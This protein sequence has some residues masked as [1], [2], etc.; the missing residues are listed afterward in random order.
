MKLYT[1]RCYGWV[2]GVFSVLLVF[3]ISS[4]GFG[5][6]GVKLSFCNE[7]EQKIFL[8]VAYEP[9]SGQPMLARGWW[10]IDAKK[11]SE[12]E[13]PLIGDK[14]MVYANSENQVTEWRGGRQ[15]CVDTTNKFDFNNAGEMSCQ[16]GT[17]ERRSFR[18]L[19]LREL[20]NSASDGMPRY[21]FTANSSTRIAD[22][23]RL[24]NDTSDTLYLSFSQKSSQDTLLAVAGW[25]KVLSGKCHETVKFS[26]SDE[27]YVF[28]NNERGDKLWKGDVPL[29]TNS[30]DGYLFTEA[31]SM[32]C[33]GNNER[34]QFFK[35]ISM[36]LTGDFEYRLKLIGSESVR[37]MVELCNTAATNIVV[38]IAAE[39][40]DFPGE[41]ISSGWFGV[42]AGACSSALA[43]SSDTMLV[44]V[45]NTEDSVLRSGT[46]PVCVHKSK[47]FEFSDSTGMMCNGDGEEKRSFDQ[48]KIEPGEIKINL[49]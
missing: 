46:F 27:L 1:L 21:A 32:D 20:I 7:N 48:I 15:L 4:V 22:A 19:S 16:G 11:C 45:E 38:A 10:P 25:F 39:N 30:Y 26:G 41:Y 34:K 49:P 36:Q 37:S 29:C 33:H 42:K 3:L 6:E 18:E 47:A 44:Y 14:F 9:Q 40:L 43:V 28:A 8:A 35:R 24:C 5:A 12:I 13:L 2:S 23:L 17:L 31:A